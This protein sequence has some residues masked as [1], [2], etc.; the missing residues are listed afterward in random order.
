M[1]LGFIGGAIIATSYELES[2]GNLMSAGRGCALARSMSFHNGR[3][4][5]LYRIV[6]DRGLVVK[7]RGAGGGS[8]T[9]LRRVRTSYWLHSGLVICMQNLSSVAVWIS[10]YLVRRSACML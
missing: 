5:L 7:R 1:E 10:Q 8:A 3:Y 4:W 6:E 2:E 9:K